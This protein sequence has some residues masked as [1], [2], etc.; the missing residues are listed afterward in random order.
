MLKISEE[1]LHM[2]NV[3]QTNLFSEEKNLGELEKLT[4]FDTMACLCSLGASYA[5]VENKK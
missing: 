4:L 3:T 5:K 2:S 1:E